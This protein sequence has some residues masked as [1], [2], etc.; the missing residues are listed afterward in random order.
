MALY[1][2]AGFDLADI[3]TYTIDVVETGGATFTTSLM[4]GTY[5]LRTDGA[6]A[7]GFV[8]DEVAAYDDFL[9]DLQ[10][11][12]DADGTAG[13]TVSFSPT[14]E[15]VTIAHDGSGGVSAIQLT[16]TANGG[17]LGHT[18]VLSGALSHELDRTPD[19]WLSGAL[20]FYGADFREYEADE[21]GF[22][23]VSHGGIPHGIP[24]D[25][26]P[27]FLDLSFPAEPRAKVYNSHATS[28]DPWTWQD[29][30]A[31]ARM[32]YPL[33][34]DDGTY[35]HFCKLTERAASFR[36]RPLATG[37]LAYWDI[38]LKPM[39]LLGRVTL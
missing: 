15:R 36:P 10:A 37:Y 29:L 28:S 3:G 17:I 1:C 26:V 12:L 13:Y 31:H 32:V 18:S 22:E 35:Q 9:G 34:I 19:Y 4:S 7:T 5:F 39:H 21:V 25:Y 2:E 30:F 11:Q 23:V 20:G 27:T 24:F 14:T 8:S 33:C 38:L 6:A 16:A